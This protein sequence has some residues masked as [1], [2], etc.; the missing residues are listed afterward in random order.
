M[1]LFCFPADTPT[2]ALVPLLHPYAH[3]LVDAI[4]VSLLSPAFFCVPNQIGRLLL[5]PFI[6][7]GVGNSPVPSPYAGRLPLCS[8]PPVVPPLDP[9]EVPPL[10]T[11]PPALGAAWTPP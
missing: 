2:A 7:S 9:T 8:P 6:C 4:A 1:V 10:S 3:V 5:C 11:F